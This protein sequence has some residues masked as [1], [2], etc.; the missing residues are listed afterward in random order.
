[1]RAWACGNTP[2]APGKYS[3]IALIAETAADARDVM[4]EGES[5]IL[6]VHPPAFRPFYEPSKRR[7]TWPNG[8]MAF[9]FNASEPDQLRGPQH[10][11]AW[12][13]ELAKWQYAEDTYAMLQ[14]GM[15]LGER[16]RYVITTTP[17]PI[18][19]LKDIMEAS[20]TVITRGATSENR[21]NLPPSFY[22]KVFK[23][24][25][26]TRLGRQELEA[27]ILD[28]NPN[29]LWS[30]ATIDD[31]RVD[32]PHDLDRIVV[33]IDPSGTRG[34]IEQPANDVGIVVVGRASNDHAYVL[35]DR[36]CNLSPG[37]WAARAIAAYHEFNCDRLVAERNFGGS[38]VEHVI[39]TADPDV[40]YREVTAS[41]GK[42][43]RAEPVAALYEQGR[44]HHVGSFPQ[45]ED[46][47]LDFT[48]DGLANG[49]SP[50]RLD[51]LVWAVTELMLKAPVPSMELGGY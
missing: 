5:G 17:R 42:W 25:G 13:D 48:P 18:R 12:C 22:E 36:T 24:Y 47:M 14:F 8:A 21:G 16:P 4:V 11:A 28:D 49:A 46:E 40:S 9:T 50:N 44:V 34:D 43:V 3:R 31:L 45:L 39:R 51:A 10:D 30:R 41:R 32:A 38:M 1:V 15:R 35:A 27:E 6:A 7:L 26:G 33:A 2:R 23:R 37:Q 20:D 29:A 19:V